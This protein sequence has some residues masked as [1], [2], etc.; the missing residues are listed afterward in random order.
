MVDPSSTV[1]I[2]IIS[3]PDQIEDAQTWHV[4]IESTLKNNKSLVNNKAIL[5][6]NL[7]TNPHSYKELT[8]KGNADP[9]ACTIGLESK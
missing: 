9:S 1:D 5:T 3:L 4:M 8:R 2:L 6:Y 7:I